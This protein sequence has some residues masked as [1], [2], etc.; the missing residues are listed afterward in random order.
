MRKLKYGYQRHHQP[1][2]SRERLLTI[3]IALLSPRIGRAPN[4]AF[5]PDFP[6]G[7]QAKEREALPL[8]KSAAP[9]TETTPSI[10]GVDGRR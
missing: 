2:E 4:T 8:Q 7:I 9:R 10:A 3:S 5:H 6:Q 1:G